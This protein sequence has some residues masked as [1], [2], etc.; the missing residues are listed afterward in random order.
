M[1]NPGF[2]FVVTLTL[3]LCGGV[4]ARTQDAK[5][6]TITGELTKDDPFDKERKKSYHKVHEL[7]LKAGETYVIDLR[8]VDFD[9][10]LRLENAAGQKLGENDD[11]SKLDLNSRL[12]FAVKKAG[13]L[14]VVVTTFAGG[15]TGRYSLY[16]RLEG[17]PLHLT[18][19]ETW[20]K[21]A[22]DHA[23]RG[24]ALLKAGKF[25]AAEEEIRKSLDLS[26]K[27]Y[28]KVRLSTRPPCHCHEAQLPRPGVRC[29]SP[30]RQSQAAF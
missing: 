29:A 24:T 23:R 30:I 9:T 13:K 14:R 4:P 25:V 26:V 18:Q 12:S 2:V 21:E 7:D 17:K 22:M 5:Q 3:C 27:L 11:V 16:V 8:S 19:E 28:P 20:H 6:I 10:F 15:L 1:R